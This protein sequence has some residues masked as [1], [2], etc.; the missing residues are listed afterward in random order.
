MPKALTLTSSIQDPVLPVVD[1]R[2]DAQR[3]NRKRKD[4][5]QVCEGARREITAAYPRWTPS[6]EFAAN[7][8]GVKRL[9][10]VDFKIAE[11]ERRLAALEIVALRKVA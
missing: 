6:S 10:V 2:T 3:R 1:L 5:H 11:L 4:T 7:G 9:A 8:A